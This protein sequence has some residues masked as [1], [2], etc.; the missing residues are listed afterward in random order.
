[1]VFLFL[2]LSLAAQPPATGTPQLPLPADRDQRLQDLRNAGV[3][4]GQIDAFL[5]GIQRPNPGMPL[6]SRGSSGFPTPLEGTTPGSQSPGDPVVEGDESVLPEDDSQYEDKPEEINEVN[7]GAR[8]SSYV[9]G[10]HLF[11][12]STPVNFDQSIGL[13]PPDDYL[14]GPGDLFTVTVYGPSEIFEDLKVTKDG[15][16]MRPRLGK[17]YVAG[18]TYAS[19]RQKITTRFQQIVFSRSNIEVH[20]TPV[21]RSLTVNIVGEVR[22]PG[23]YRIPASTPA[24][25]ALFAAGGINNI[26]SVRNIQIKRGNKTV[27]VLDLYE[28]LIKGNNSPIF[29]QEND[30]IYVPVQQK[31]VGIKGAINRPMK[32]E[33]LETENLK[34]LLK[35]A[36]GLSYD[37][38]RKEAQIARLDRASEREVLKDF[39]LGEYLADPNR[40]YLLLDGDQVII[41]EVNKGAYNIVQVFG[42]VE[43]PSTYQLRPGERASDLI[44]RAGGL[45]IDAYLDRAYV[46]RIVPNSTE[47]IYIPIDLRAIAANPDDANNIQLQFFDALLVFSETDFMD[48]RFIEVNGQ[49]RK[50]GT[51]RI[52]QTMTLKDLLFLVG[53]LKKD[54]DFNNLELSITTQAENLD[55]ESDEDS[56]NEDDDPAGE[57]EATVVVGQA[58]AMDL[59]GG[60]GAINRQIVERISIPENWQEDPFIDTL[61]IYQFDKLNVYS[62]Y[63]FLFL[64]YIEIDGSVKNPGKYQLQRGMTLRDVLY[65]AGGLAED[66]DV[67][68]VELYRDIPLTKR[69]NYNTSSREPEIVRIQIDRDW[70][71][72]PVTD[73]LMVTDF[74]RVIIR[75]E[76]DFFVP[77]YVEIQGLVNNPD[78]FEV[79]PNMTL[80]DL[81]YMA[82]GIQMEANFERIELA[83]VIEV[84]NDLGEI[85]PT[86][87]VIGFVSTRQDWQNDP[88]LDSVKL[89]AYDIVY[90]RKNPDFELQERVYIHGEVHVEG[91]YSKEYKAEPISKLVARAG[92]ITDLAYLEGA[93]LRRAQGN[94]GNVALKLEKAIRRPG[95]KF[96]I[97]LL[98]GDTLVIPA[99]LD[100]ITVTG[101]VLKPDN[102]VLFEPRHRKVKHYIRLAG[103]FDRRTKKRQTTV[104]HVDGR[105]NSTRT[106]LWMKKYPKLEQGALITV[107][108]KPDK[109]ER[110]PG[111]PRVRISLQETLAMLTSLLTFYLLV[112]R[113]ILDNP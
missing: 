11:S 9:F 56:G 16:V 37:A 112:D 96:D 77:G 79:L 52:S 44:D 87:V 34:T 105:V 15:S 32:Y 17:I 108:R 99:R 76:S 80:K 74:H 43:Y 70:Q 110:G 91:E 85:I 83:R 18:L 53:G 42:N 46:V 23:A 26:G 107:A 28:Y 100:I 71:S 84:E 72:S 49:V 98:E 68:E 29:L 8:R 65:Q 27:E 103:G 33:L 57:G 104:T 5:Q 12:D 89:N 73:S 41:N 109:P 31:I 75:S 90:V 10:H 97:S 40:E 101:N 64:K 92:G 63:D 4:Q 50:T 38:L 48:E 51:Y 25:N 20:L 35:F 54:A 61:Q 55:I 19:A 102:T 62:K 94:I 78:T 22:K 113:T 24:F 60:E 36:G 2:G 111:Q 39:D 47:N 59:D 21:Q 30:F 67:N 88:R 106:F 45:G 69:G 14:V 7:L 95:S 86:P 82:E 13:V 3:P 66:A 93:Y 1:M 81:I 6:D 58:P